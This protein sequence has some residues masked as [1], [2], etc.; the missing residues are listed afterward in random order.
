MMGVV[1]LSL[2]EAAMLRKGDD[3]APDRDFLRGDDPVFFV[4][5]G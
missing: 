5:S 3:L 2:P 4:L 1:G